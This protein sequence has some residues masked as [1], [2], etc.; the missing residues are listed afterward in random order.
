MDGTRR[1]T[2]VRGI[3]LASYEVGRATGDPVVIVPG[4]CVSSYLWPACDALARHGFRVEL[5]EPPGWPRSAPA[6]PEPE[7]LADLARWVTDWLGVRGLTDVLLIGQSVG[8]QLA[9]HVAAQA[10]GRLRALL[11]QGPVFD[12]S[13]RTPAR[14]LA[15]WAADMPREHPGLALRE[16]PEWVRVGPR[17]VRHVLRLALAD[18]PEE[19]LR[20]TAT[21][22]Q[23]VVGEHDPL[24]TPGWRGR[25]G[26]V[27]VMRGCP[28]SAPHR[29]PEAFARLVLELY[30]RSSS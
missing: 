25:L 4:L 28:H 11:L 12:P 21:D 17:R 22:V 1:D 18:R 19:T 10:P 3:R 8:A 29:A 9:T 26:E 2:W 14:A 13:C 20:K 27:T 30:G 5:V 16:V 23:V 6:R 7:D 15:R 24:S